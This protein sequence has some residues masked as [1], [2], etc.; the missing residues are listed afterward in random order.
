MHSIDDGRDV[1]VCGSLGGVHRAPRQEG[2]TPPPP[3]H[4][5]CL[6]VHLPGRAATCECQTCPVDCVDVQFEDN[7]A[8]KEMLTKVYKELM[9]LG[10]IAFA[11]GKAKPLC[12][13]CCHC[14]RTPDDCTRVC[15]GAGDPMQGAAG[16]YVEPRDA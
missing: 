12:R 2:V 10:F 9:I 13:G 4:S 16:D 7:V 15:R 3:R 1:G 14:Q 8:H 6:R 11:V 5:A